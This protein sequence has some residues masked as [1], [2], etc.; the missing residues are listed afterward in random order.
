MWLVVV[1]ENYYP[2]VLHYDSEEEARES[3][4]RNKSEGY[5][6]HIAKVSETYINPDEADGRASKDNC[7]DVEWY[8]VSS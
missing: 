3:F 4:E 8:G 6:T 7:W 1:V 5:V 2:S